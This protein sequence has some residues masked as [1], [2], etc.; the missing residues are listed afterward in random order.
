MF[1]VV[2]CPPHACKHIHTHLHTTSEHRKS[3]SD[4][5][6]GNQLKDRRM[7]LAQMATRDSLHPGDN[8]P[9]KLVQ[10]KDLTDSLTRERQSVGKEN[11]KGREL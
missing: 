4:L 1:E 2:L 6:A 5:Q 8:E 7:L 11:Q 10:P 3:V 9:G